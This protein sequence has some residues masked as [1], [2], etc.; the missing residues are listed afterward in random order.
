VIA[1]VVDTQNPDNIFRVHLFHA[2]PAFLRDEP[3]PTAF[4]GLD[5]L[6][7][8]Q[9]FREKL[10]P[11]DEKVKQHVQKLLLT[12]TNHPSEID[13]SELKQNELSVDAGEATRLPSTT[14]G[15]TSIPSTHKTLFSYQEKKRKLQEDQRKTKKQRLSHSHDTRYK[16]KALPQLNLQ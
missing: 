14:R 7:E 12:P 10:S 1:L 2:K 9:C 15:P 16:R 6:E 11:E 13:V 4:Y 5:S 3:G 8:K